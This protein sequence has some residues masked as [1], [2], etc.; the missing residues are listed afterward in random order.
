MLFI[1]GHFT[2]LNYDSRVVLF[3]NGPLGISR[4]STEFYDKLLVYKQSYLCNQ[5]FA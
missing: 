2:I 5:T 4:L 1:C 3:R